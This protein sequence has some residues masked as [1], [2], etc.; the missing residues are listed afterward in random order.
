[1]TLVTIVMVFGYDKV[2]VTAADSS[3]LHVIYTANRRLDSSN[4][5][6]CVLCLDWCSFIV[7]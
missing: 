5:I 4:E 6:T 3:E 2:D 7:M 1:M